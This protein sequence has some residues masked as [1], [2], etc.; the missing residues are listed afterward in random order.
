MAFRA[1]LHD[2]RLTYAVG[3]SSNTT[4]FRGTP[5]LI[6]PPREAQEHAQRRPRP[7]LSKHDKPIKVSA[8]AAALPPTAWRRITWRNGDHAPRAARFAA[9][10]VTPAKGWCVCQRILAPQ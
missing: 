6:P 9:C 2:L 10:R 8:L 4:V 3:I 5:Q 1:A 7:T